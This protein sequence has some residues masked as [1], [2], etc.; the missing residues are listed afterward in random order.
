MD[1]PAEKR[2][3]AWQPLTPRGVA[4]FATASFGRLWVVQLI[5]ACLAGLCIIWFLNRAWAPVISAAIEQLPARSEIRHAKLNWQDLSPQCLAENRFL[6]ISID[7]NHQGKARSPAHVQIELGDSTVKVLSLLG[8]IEVSYPD[9]W[10]IALGRAEVGPWWGAW[11]PALLAIA[12]GAVLV[13]LMLLWPILALLYSGPAWLIAYFSNRE[14]TWLG[15]WRLAQAALVPAALLFSLAVVLYGLGIL[16][17]LLLFIAFG[18]HILVGWIY[19]ATAAFCLPLQKDE[20][21]VK[22]NPF[23]AKDG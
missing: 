19:A 15:S 4:A 22:E 21:P 23:T 12:G 5:A 6:A 17:L 2:Q 13:A 8:F 1:K 16:D 10:R 3:F 14:T 11:K 9:G 18:L 20:A 7:L